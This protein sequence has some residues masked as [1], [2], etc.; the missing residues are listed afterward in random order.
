MVPDARSTWHRALWLRTLA[1]PNSNGLCSHTPNNQASDWND[2]DNHW[3]SW[4]WRSWNN[5]AW[6]WQQNP[7]STWQ[8]ESAPVQEAK[9]RNSPLVRDCWDRLTSD[10]LP[11]QPM[12]QGFSDSSLACNFSFSDAFPRILVFVVQTCLLRIKDNAGRTGPRSQQ[13]PPSNTTSAAKIDACQW[14]LIFVVHSC[15]LM[16]QC[17]NQGAIL[18]PQGSRG[19]EPLFAIMRHV[20]LPERCLEDDVL[21]PTD[22]H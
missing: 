20:A 18:L 12:K 19:G 16:C 8:S 5:D 11:Q 22:G 7:R 10:P 6:Q 17:W 2:S 14:I 4:D 3:G 13:T 9:L 1:L 15:L 21:S